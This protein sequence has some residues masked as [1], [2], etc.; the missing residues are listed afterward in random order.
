MKFVSRNI[1]YWMD[2]K[3][4]AQSI[5]WLLANPH[6]PLNN[7]FAFDPKTSRAKL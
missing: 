2:W 1:L 4:T 6:I 7:T 5:N 3:T